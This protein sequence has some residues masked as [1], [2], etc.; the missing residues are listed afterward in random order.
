[1]LQ[2]WSVEMYQEQKFVYKYTRVQATQNITVQCHITICISSLIYWKIYLHWASW[3]QLK[4]TTSLLRL[5]KVD[6][7]LLQRKFILHCSS[8]TF[9]NISCSDISTDGL[10]YLKETYEPC[11]MARKLNQ[12]NNWDLGEK[13]SSRMKMHSD[14]NLAYSLM[15]FPVKWLNFCC[16]NYSNMGQG[17]IQP[18]S[19]LNSLAGN[20]GRNLDSRAVPSSNSNMHS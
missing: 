3:Q 6:C 16:C 2:A 14:R 1:M 10:K 17:D 19:F 12:A 9:T 15:T 20:S 8:H 4:L 13:V 11:N 5:S 7:S 18:F